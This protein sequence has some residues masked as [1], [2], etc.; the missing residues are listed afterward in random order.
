MARHPAYKD[1]NIVQRAAT[2]SR[3]IVTGSTY[4]SNLMTDKA[5]SFSRNTKPNAKPLVFSQTTHN[6]VRK[7]NSFT[8]GVAGVSSKTVGQITKV[9]Q[10]ATARP[11]IPRAGVRRVPRA[12]HSAPSARAVC[13]SSGTDGL[14]MGTNDYRR[15]EQ[16]LREQDFFANT[17][18]ALDDYIA[19]GQ[20][21]LGDLHVQREMLKHTQKRIYSAANTLGISGDTI[22]MVERRAKEDKWIFAVGTVVFFLFCWACLHYLR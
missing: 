21:V 1:S 3:L 16:A 5:D 18:S 14:G 13:Q 4:L 19:R 11:R 7:I 2:A 6:R 15:E 22:R 17:H 20:E 9:T 8:T 12:R 10:N